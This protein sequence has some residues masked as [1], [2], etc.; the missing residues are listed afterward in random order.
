MIV[1]DCISIQH[2]YNGGYALICQGKELT[3]FYY[4]VQDIKYIFF[5]IF[6]DLELNFFLLVDFMLK[7]QMSCIL[8]FI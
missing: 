4:N 5:F 8:K 1:N 6:V 7:G 3:H 2:L